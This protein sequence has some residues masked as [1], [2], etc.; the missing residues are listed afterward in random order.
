MRIMRLL[1]LLAAAATS[2]YAGPSLFDPGS[3]LDVRS[4]AAVFSN[5]AWSSSAALIYPKSD[6][7]NIAALKDPS[8]VHYNGAYH[9][10]ASTAVASGYNVSIG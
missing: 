6:S 9:V 8:V 3:P 1:A 5:F 2:V 7:H 10:F 4:A